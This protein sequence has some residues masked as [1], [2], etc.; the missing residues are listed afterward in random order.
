M[1]QW[2]RQLDNWGG[3]AIFIS[4]CS[5]LLTS[6]KSIDFMV[7]E[8]KY[9]NIHPPPPNYRAGGATANFETVD[10]HLRDGRTPQFSAPASSGRQR[11][12]F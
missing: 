1:E 12:L 8:H 11:K 2:C 3:G 10:G 9:M 7:C 4:L 6:F 5:A